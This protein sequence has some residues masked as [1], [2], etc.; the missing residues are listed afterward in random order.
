MP[1]GAQAVELPQ[2]DRPRVTG[3]EQAVTG[4]E[5]DHSSS[6]SSSSSASSSS[7]SRSAPTG[8]YARSCL[9]RSHAQLRTQPVKVRA[10]AVVL[11]L[12]GNLHLLGLGSAAPHWLDPLERPEPVRPHDV[13]VAGFPHNKRTRL[14]PP[15]G[16]RRAP[17]SVQVQPYLLCGP[18]AY[19]DALHAVPGPARIVPC[20]RFNRRARCRGAFRHR[21]SAAPRA[22]QPRPTAALP[23]L[24][25]SRRSVMWW[26]ISARRALSRGRS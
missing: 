22:G 3:S 15:I 4:Y 26:Q 11:E 17:A 1:A 16:V 14:A 12:A 9:I 6:S 5:A 18:H 25:R 8:S 10:A 2:A 13:C 23:R 7:S 21:T 20:G 24:P 19:A